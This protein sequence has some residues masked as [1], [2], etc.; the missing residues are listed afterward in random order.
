MNMIAFVRQTV[1]DGFFGAKS[2]LG[3]DDGVGPAPIRGNRSKPR[4][5]W[6]QAW[7]F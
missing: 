6:F 4:Q 1:E 3:D 7:V 5:N 2:L